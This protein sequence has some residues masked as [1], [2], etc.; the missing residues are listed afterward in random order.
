MSLI[1]PPLLYLV[2]DAGHFVTAAPGF[3]D[4][5]ECF[6]RQSTQTNNGA[7]ERQQSRT[8][9]EIAGI[10]RVNAPPVRNWIG[11]RDAAGT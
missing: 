11:P 10:L 4:R 9:Q 3:A 6:S 1:E 8:V 2:P 7:A 5:L